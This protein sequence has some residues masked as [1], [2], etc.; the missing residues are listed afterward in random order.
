MSEDQV[1]NEDAYILFYQRSTVAKSN[2]NWFHSLPNS[3]KNPPSGKIEML[4][5]LVFPMN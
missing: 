2:Q 4:I 1:V 3:A 5:K